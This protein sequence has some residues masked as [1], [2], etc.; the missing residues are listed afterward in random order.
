MTRTSGCPAFPKRQNCGGRKRTLA[1]AAAA[2]PGGGFPRFP[3][4]HGTAHYGLEPC[5]G[6]G[7]GHR[8]HDGPVPYRRAEGDPD[9]HPPRGDSRA[10]LHVPRAQRKRAAQAGVSRRAGLPQPATGG[11]R[12]LSIT[13]IR[14]PE[15]VIKLEDRLNYL[16]QPPLEALLSDRELAMPLAA[17][18]LS[19]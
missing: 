12:K 6:T 1:L 4:R 19:V 9:P 16:L 8:G 10:E 2:S 17:V 14:P 15:D 11:V 3:F 7:G 18:P 5:P 13:R